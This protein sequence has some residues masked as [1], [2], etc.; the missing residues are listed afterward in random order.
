MGL[1]SLPKEFG[2]KPV[3]TWKLKPLR[4]KRTPQGKTE[5]KLK[6]ES[7]RNTSSDL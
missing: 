6:L 2:N 4:Q 1:R 3:K 7:L 5:Q